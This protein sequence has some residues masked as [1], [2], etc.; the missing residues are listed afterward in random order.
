VAEPRRGERP[1]CER[2]LHLRRLAEQHGKRQV[3]GR[4]GE[5]GIIDRQVRVGHGPAHDGKGA[6]LAMADLGEPRQMLFGNRQHVAF[7]CLVAPDFQRRHARVRVG[8]VTQLKMPA[9]ARV[10]DQLRKGIGQPAGADIVNEENG[11]S[12]S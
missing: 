10:L 11:I 6:A 12:L 1:R 7:L 9:D 2:T 5:L 3:H 8:H 4:V